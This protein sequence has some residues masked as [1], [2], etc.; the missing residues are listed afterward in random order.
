VILH[1]TDRRGQ[2][3]FA[4]SQAARQIGVQTGM[5]LAEARA[6]ALRQKPPHPNPLPQ[7]GRGDKIFSPGGTGVSP[8]ASDKSFHLDAHD[9][10]ADRRSLKKLAEWLHQY[11]PCIGLEDLDPPETLLLDVT[12]IGR[13]FGGERALLTQVARG[14]ARFGLPARL[15]LADSLGAAWAIAHYACK[16]TS[17]RIV[18]PGEVKQTIENLPLVALRLPHAMLDTFNGLG[19]ESIADLLLLPRVEVQARFGSLPLTRIDQALGKADEVIRAVPLPSELAAK[20]WFEHPIA[21]PETIEHVLD[22]LTERLTCAL[23]HRGEGALGVQCA[24]DASPAV[25]FEVGLF[26]PT[27]DV[28][29]LRE[30]IDLQMERVVLRSPIGGIGLRVPRFAPLE[31]Q[32][33]ELFSRHQQRHDSHQVATLVDRLTSRLG[34]KAVVGCTTR[35]DPQPEIAYHLQPLV[36]QSRSNKKSSVKHRQPFAPLDRP[37]QLLKR[38]L[39]LETLAVSPEGPPIRFDFRGQCQEVVR[40]WGPERIETGWWR[41]RGVRRDYYRVETHTG[42]RF[43]LFRQIGS[44]ECFLHGTF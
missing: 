9:P 30:L 8:V 14:L 3:V 40:H 10:E 28:R 32:Q 38:P 41:R 16:R 27:A 33:G 34:E 5:P 17:W 35:S 21:H 24:F 43:W 29:H 4:C 18:P 1:R 22:Q 19:I 7:G 11:S 15:A 13:L 6:L 25:Q 44:G 2:V 36:R 20:W 37:P 39:R 12:G 31:W 42:H 23:A 26:R